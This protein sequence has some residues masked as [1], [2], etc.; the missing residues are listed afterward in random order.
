MQSTALSL[1]NGDH[2]LKIALI[3]DTH[4][5]IRNDSQV[6][7]DYF[8]RFLDDVFFPMLEKEGIKQVIHLGD[9]VDRRKYANYLTL[10]RL[11]R[12][13]LEECE[14]RCIDV[15]IIPGNHDVFYKNTNEINALRE[16]ITGRY[17]FIHVIEKPVTITF[18]STDILLLPW[19]CEDN[20][21]ESMNAIKT[22]TG[23][24]VCGHLE[25]N[26]FEMFKGSISDHGM[27]H[28]L[29][30]RFDVVCSGH[31][32]HKSDTGNIHYLGAFAE[33][34]W[35]D[36]DDPRGFHVFDTEI[37]ELTFIRNPY[38]MFEKVWYDDAG[39]TVEEVVFDREIDVR[40]K[41]VKLIVKNKTNP[42]WFDLFV[43]RIEKEGVIDL[44][45]VEDH[46]HLD[47][48][49]DEDIIDEAEDTLTVCKK[50]ISS[51]NLSVD[52]KKLDRVITNLY[53]EAL[54]IE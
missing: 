4:W 51:M 50:Y 3:A 40:N 34:T 20:Y 26:G 53:T 41:M 21:E 47:L 9:L 6:F 52:Q 35:S 46:L 39:K 37:R 54:Q 14:R 13:F 43:D 18:D 24:V 1:N 28:K 48:L 29:F 12:D 42:Y 22:T 15:Y 16:I 19:I 27:D 31:Y 11:R 44:Q 49:A 23:Q 10:S 25:L 30:D 8:K 38:R 33:Y 5:G 17:Q 45:V 2:T 32:H 7:Y 36:F